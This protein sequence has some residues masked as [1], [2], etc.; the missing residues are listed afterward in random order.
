VSVAELDALGREIHGA[1]S[2]VVKRS[3]AA[4]PA[5]VLFSAGLDSAVLLAHALGVNGAQP[6]Y[7]RAGLAWEDD[8]LIYANHLL[9]APLFREA[10]PLA[11][12]SV[13]MRDVYPAGHWAVRGEAPGFD[14]PDSDVYL[15]GR[16]VVL[17]AKASVF[18]VR[19]KLNR[20]MLGPLAGNPFPDA[21]PEFFA[22]MATAL[23][24]GLAAPIAI[25]APFAAMHKADVIR[26]GANLGVPFELTLSCMQPR[27]G[28][29]C[30]RCSKCRERRDGFVE[31]KIPDPTPYAAK[32]LR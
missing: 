6:I 26:L 7:V 12:L 4:Q 16:N 21:T 1:E 27:H 17:L 13:D 8:E 29:H 20:V 5:A 18:M 9:R 30:G 19:A 24:L 14:T 28:L 2:M 3:D 31:A 22:G 25:E 23:S 10:A 15:E 11:T 32:P